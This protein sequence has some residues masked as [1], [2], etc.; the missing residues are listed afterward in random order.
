LSLINIVAARIPIILKI[1]ALALYFDVRSTGTK[2]VF[3]KGS[4]CLNSGVYLIEESF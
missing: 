1:P 2:M 3:P 4:T